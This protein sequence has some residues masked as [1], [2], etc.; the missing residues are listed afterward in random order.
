MGAQVQVAFPGIIVTGGVVS[1]HSA[2]LYDDGGEVSCLTDTVSYHAR[3]PKQP[4]SRGSSSTR[5]WY[6]ARWVGL[7]ISSLEPQPAQLPQVGPSGA[8]GLGLSGG[9]PSGPAVPA[10]DR[11]VSSH[12]A[13]PMLAGNCC[14]L[15]KGPLPGC[16]Q[17]SCA[18]CCGLRRFESSVECMTMTVATPSSKEHLHPFC[19]YGMPLIKWCPI[20]AHQAM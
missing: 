5:K 4:P 10:G 1:H 11:L 19:S 18:L 12:C 3:N 9:L 8:P 15:S 20:Q 13:P 7:V 17:D 16:L 2:L 6:R 14:E